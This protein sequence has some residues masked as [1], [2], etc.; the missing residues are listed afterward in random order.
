[1]YK[2]DAFMNGHIQEM[3]DALKMAE[4]AEKLQGENE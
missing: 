3:I 4:N 2:L 1:L